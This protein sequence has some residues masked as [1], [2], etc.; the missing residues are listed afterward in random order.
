MPA[1]VDATASLSGAVNGKASL[2]VAAGKST[3]ISIPAKGKSGEA[4]FKIV[5]ETNGRPTTQT[6]SVNVSAH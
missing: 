1:Q 3:V 6:A 2:K 4:Q 5:L